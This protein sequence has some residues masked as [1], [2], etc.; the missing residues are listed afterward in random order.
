M[1]LPILAAALLI[2]AGGTA[3]AQADMVMMD[4]PHMERPTSPLIQA[5]VQDAGIGNQFEMTLSQMALQKSQDP[6]V[7]RFA[8]RMLNDHHMAELTLEHAAAPTGVTTHFMFDQAHQAKLDE[9]QA[10]SGPAFD[11]Q[12]WILQRDAHAAAV[13]AIGDYATTGSDPG[14]RAWAR[15]TLPVIVAHQRMIADLTGTSAVALR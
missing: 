15:G 14:L 13:A 4:A 11:Q 5:F 1:R 2:G 3:F 9:L 8:Q 6:N 10:L 7:R 12:F